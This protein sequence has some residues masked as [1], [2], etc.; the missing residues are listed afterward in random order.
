MPISH[1]Q[2]ANGG[3]SASVTSATATG[4]AIGSGNTVC[5]IVFW[6]NT[7]GTLTSVTDNKGNTYTIVDSIQETGGANSF[8][9]SFYLVNVTGGPTALTANLGSA[10]TGVQIS[11][12]EYSGVSTSAVLDGHHGQ[13]QASPGT[14]TDAISSGSFT[15][16][17]NGDLIYCGSY[18]VS[19]TS[20]AGTGFTLELNNSALN[21]LV[22]L[23]TEDEVQSSAGSV[24]GTF[25]QNNVSY[26]VT[27]AL[28]LGVAA[29]TAFDM[30]SRSVMVLP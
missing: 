23:S 17:D 2:N 13:A 22:F 19:G 18:S 16:A 6:H 15:T 9:A 12:D 1:V 11:W 8:L 20:S 10:T 3:S 7:A 26:T 27:L 30:G 24:S 28:A 4:S 21:G 25:T 5:G 29:A 14:G